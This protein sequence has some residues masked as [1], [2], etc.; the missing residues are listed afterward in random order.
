MT[1]TVY[2]GAPS[3]KLKKIYEWVRKAQSEAMKQIKP[4][5]TLKQADAMARSV[6]EKGGFGKEFCHSLGHGIGLEVH[7]WPYLRKA[8]VDGD[9][10][11]EAGM[12]VTVEP[13]IY[14]PGLG[15]VRIEDTIL[16]TP[17]GNRSLTDRP[18]D[19]RVV[20]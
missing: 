12:C 19:L 1:R 8:G 11:L 15:G 5:V 7:E 9:T 18:T 3:P 4:G 10:P 17:K 6:I 16:I 14:L 20:N 2:F 13:G